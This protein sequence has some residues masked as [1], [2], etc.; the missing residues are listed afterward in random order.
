MATPRNRM[1]DVLSEDKFRSALS[2]EL[3]GMSGQ[4][5]HPT[6]ESVGVILGHWYH[7]LHYFPAFLS[8]LVSVAP[9]IE[10]QTFISRILWQELGQGDPALAHEKI[11][12]DTMTNAGFPCDQVTGSPAFRA[13]SDLLNGYETA[14]IDYLFGLGFLYGTEVADL[15]MV[16]SIGAVVRKC[17]GKQNLPWVDIHV[18]QEP[19]HVATSVKTL[20]LTFSHDE[21]GKIVSAAEEMWSLWRAFFAELKGRVFQ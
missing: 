21:Q 4:L 6:V 11:Y 16:S 10:A 12:I 13:T 3:K 15:A 2:V 20:M 18:E 1:L 7:P 5:T 17:T 19:D 8:R 14:S 9:S